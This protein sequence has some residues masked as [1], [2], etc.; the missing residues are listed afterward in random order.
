[1]QSVVRAVALVRRMRRI[2]SRAG[3]I[4]RGGFMPD[5]LRTKMAKDLTAGGYIRC[6]VFPMTHF[7]KIR[8]NKGPS[9]NPRDVKNHYNI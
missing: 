7:T 6:L 1:M 5:Y 3:F 4:P 8:G 9:S 2:K